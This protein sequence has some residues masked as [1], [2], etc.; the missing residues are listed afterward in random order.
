MVPSPKATPHV[1]LGHNAFSK[2]EKT[3][4]RSVADRPGLV[5]AFRDQ[6]KY[7]SPSDDIMSPATQKLNAYKS[8]HFS[9]AK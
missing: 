1:L 3:K 8:K 9:T 6:Q 4:R 7:I 5:V 2:G